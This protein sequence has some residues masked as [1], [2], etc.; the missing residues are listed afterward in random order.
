MSRSLFDTLP[1]ELILLVVD[2]LGPADLVSFLRLIRWLPSL[3]KDKQIMAEDQMGSTILHLL[4]EEGEADLI[5]LLLLKGNIHPDPRNRQSG[6]TP[7]HFA[8]MNGRKETVELLLIKDG[9]NPDSRDFSGWTPLWW[10][11]GYSHVEVMKILRTQG[12][13]SLERMVKGHTLLSWAASHGQKETVKALLEMDGINLNPVDKTHGRTPL[14]WAALGR[15]TEVVE[16]FLKKDGVDA[17]SISRTIKAWTPVNMMSTVTA[18]YELVAM[19]MRD[20]PMAA[21]HCGRALAGSTHLA[22]SGPR[23]RPCVRGICGPIPQK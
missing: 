13:A 11:A 5:D 3:L 14:V 10:A 6:R 7:L 1:T 4:A 2:N 17:D 12:N 8:A 9:V 19:L 15:H 18:D 23:E 22:I 20:H 16:L 21:L